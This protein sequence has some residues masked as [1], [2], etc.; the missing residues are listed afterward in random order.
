MINELCQS[1]SDDS[2][3]S[4]GSNPA[5]VQRRD[6]IKS[7]AQEEFYKALEDS[8]SRYQV[9]VSTEKGKTSFLNDLD[10]E[11]LDI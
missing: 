2:S 9:Q 7:S 5:K 10:L 1:S 8:P 11:E 4:E 3:S 6:A